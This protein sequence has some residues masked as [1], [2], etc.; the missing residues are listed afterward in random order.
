MTSVKRSRCQQQHMKSPSSSRDESS[1]SD[2]CVCLIPPP[3]LL[4]PP[5]TVSSSK[6]LYHFSRSLS[7]FL[8]ILALIL[9][10]GNPASSTRARKS[11]LNPRQ[12]FIF[13]NLTEDLCV[14]PYIL[15]FFYSLLLYSSIECMYA[16]VCRGKIRQVNAAE[17]L[18][19]SKGV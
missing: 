2:S 18:H 1:G 19:T 12:S 3:P 10:S 5:L 17:V 8:C 7:V 13:L 15:G 9:Y 16:V 4:F 6:S 14:N 11:R